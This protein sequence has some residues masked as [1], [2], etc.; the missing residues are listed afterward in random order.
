MIP[1]Q[2]AQE[3]PIL[4]APTTNETRE[5]EHEKDQLAAQDTP[6]LETKIPEHNSIERPFP[7]SRIIRLNSNKRA[8]DPDSEFEFSQEVK[9]L[10]SMIA[11]L[12]WF[13]DEEEPIELKEGSAMIASAAAYDILI[14]INYKEAVNDP[15]YGAAW[16]IA[17]NLEIGQLLTN[18]IWEEKVP[19]LDVNLISSKWVFTLKFNPDG[20]LERY[21]ARLVA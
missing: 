2:L 10:R 8:N 3:T 9:R 21:K 1:Q 7:N 13:H 11:V 20:I 18:N 16:R 14:S 4:S 17:I 5:K 19:S 6:D 15:T 12:D